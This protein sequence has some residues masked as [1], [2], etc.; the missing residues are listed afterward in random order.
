LGLLTAPLILLGAFYFVADPFK[1]VR[2]YS[3]YYVSGQ[4]TFVSLNRGYV[5]AETYLRYR[6]AQRYDSF[7]FGN[8]RS[9]FYPVA[10]WSSYIG[11]TNCFHFDASEESLAGLQRKVLWLD[12]GGAP[13]RHVLLILDAA[14]L[15]R[16]NNLNGHL[17]L[18]HPALSGQVPLGFQLVF[19]KTFFEPRFLAAYLD[20]RWSHGVKPY[21]LAQGLLDNR[22]VTYRLHANELSFDSFEALIRTNPVAYYQPRTDFFPA[23]PARPDTAPPVIHAAQRELLAAMASVFQRQA[24]DCRVVINPLYDQVRLN[25]ADLESLRRAFGAANVHDFSGKNAMTEPMTNYYESSHYRPHVACQ[26]LAAVYA[27]ASRVGAQPTGGASPAS[28]LPWL[29]PVP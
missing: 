4:P 14:T 25:P 7:I 19:L 8:S 13:L 2:E 17:F 10:D 21:M 11:S 27:K 1:V 3:S 9:L 29:S 5:S 20:F 24:T 18:D 6:G 26:V 23:R 12:R 16:T 28:A 22:P 15:A